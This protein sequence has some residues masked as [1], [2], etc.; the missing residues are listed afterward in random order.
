MCSKGLVLIHRNGIQSFYL[1]ISRGHTLLK[2]CESRTIKHQRYIF[3][4]LGKVYPGDV[5]YI[6][7]AKVKDLCE[8]YSIF[9]KHTNHPVDERAIT[10]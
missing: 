3:F 2:T 1:L 6:E 10:A 5:L 9:E 4:P 7:K 8:G